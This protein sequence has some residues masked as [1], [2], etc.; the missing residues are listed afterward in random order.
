MATRWIT[1]ATALV[2][3]YVVVALALNPAG[4]P[5][6]HFLAYKAKPPK[7]APRFAR[8]EV[9]LL[10][11]FESVR[12]NVIKPH[13]ILVPANKNAEGILDDATHLQA[14]KIKSV[15]G[16]PKHVRRVGL[17]VSDQFGTLTLD[18]IKPELLLVPSALAHLSPPPS[19]NPS[20][21]NVDHFKCYKV[22]I[23]KGAPK[24]PSN[25][26]PVIAD[27]FEPQA[28]GFRLVKPLLLCL[29]V[30]KNGEGLKNPAGLLTCYKPKL[31]RGEPKH[32]R[33]EGAHISDQ[34][35]SLIL[36]TIKE[37]EF[38]VPSVFTT[39]TP[40]VTPIGP[41][42]SAT[43][44]ATPLP[45]GAGCQTETLTGVWQDDARSE[46]LS[47]LE[48]QSG[49][50]VGAL[51]SAVGLPELA[52][53]V[54]GAR[55]GTQIN[56][57]DRSGNWEVC[58]Q[59]TLSDGAE[60][61]TYRRVSLYG[62]GNGQLEPGEQCDD[63]NLDNADGCTVACKTTCG[64]GAL[65]PGEQCDGLVGVCASG[66]C[67]PNCTCTPV[68]GDAT[69][70]TP[71]EVCDGPDLAGNT[72]ASLGYSGGTLACVAACNG[73]DSSGCTLPA[74][75][76]PDP[77]TIAP[78]LDDSVVTT[79]FAQT[80]FLFTGPDRVQYGV[81][82]AV[83]DPMRA[84]VL[85]G[86][87]LHRDGFPVSG[88]TV[89]V[90]SHPEF[91]RTVSRA[92][93]AFDLAVNGGGLLLVDYRS[94]AFLP[95]QRKIDVPWQGF[96]HLPDVVLIPV[97]SQVSTITV[98]PAAPAQVAQG[99][100]VTDERGTRRAAVFFPTGT[101]AEVILPD[102]S[103][104]EVSTL[105]LRF[106][107]Y[108]VGASG[109]EAMPGVLP[110]TNGYTYAV[111]ISADEAPTK[112]N[113]R[114]VLLSQP[115]PLYVDNFLNFPVGGKVPSAYYDSDHGSWIPVPDGRVIRILDTTGGIAEVDTDGDLVA[116]DPAT[117]A[118]L[119]VTSEERQQL[120]SLYEPGDTL[121]RVQVTHLS[122]YDCNWPSP[123]SFT[124][125]C[126][127]PAVPTPTPE[128]HEPCPNTV[129]GSIVDCEN[130]TLGE[131]IPIVGTSFALNYSSK[132]AANFPIPLDIPITGPSVPTDLQS[133]DL[134]VSVAGR[135]FRH[136]FGSAPGQKHSFV[137]DR[138]DVYGRAVIGAERVRVVR[139]YMFPSAFAQ[140]GPFN[141]SFGLPA[142][143][144]SLDGSGQSRRLE[145]PVESQV[146]IGQLDA[147][148]VGLGGWTLDVHRYY[149]P[150]HRVLYLGSGQRR[151][152]SGSSIQRAL[153]NPALDPCS[154]GTFE[155]VESV[156]EGRD[157][158]VYVGDRTVPLCLSDPGFARG[159]IHRYRPDGTYER[160]AGGGA[161][162]GA[163]DGGPATAA[164]I[165]DPIDLAIGPDDS[166]HILEFDDDDLTI[167]VRRVRPDGTIET[168]AG[169][170]PW[171][172]PCNEDPN[173][174]P[175]TEINLCQT[176]G[177]DV[178]PDGTLYI[179][180]TDMGRVLAVRADG[181]VAT[182]A[183]GGFS[184]ADGIAALDALLESPWDVAVGP[185]GAIYFSDRANGDRVRRVTPD[186]VID[187]IAGV[188]G[189]QGYNG[190]GGPA[191]EAELSQPFRLALAATDN[192]TLY[193]SEKSASRVRSV[194]PDG[195][196]QTVAGG[197]PDLEFL[198]ENEGGPAIGFIYEGG[199]FGAHVA[200][201]RSGGFYLVAPGSHEDRVLRV[202]S[203]YPGFHGGGYVI[204]SS[205]GMELYHFESDGR[206]RQTRSAMTGHVLY[207]FLYTAQGRL[208]EVVD[209]DGNRTQIERDG[210][211][212]PTA[213]IAPFGQRTTLSLDS[214]GYLNLIEN[215][216][217]EAH[218]FTYSPEG[219]LLT[220]TDPR[221]FTSEYDY[222]DDGRL[223]FAEDP[224]GGSHTISRTTDPDDPGEVEIT[225]MTALGRQTRYVRQ[226]PNDDTLPPELLRPNLSY[227]RTTIDPDGTFN[228][229]WVRT[230]GIT[231]TEDSSGVVTISR[232][233]GDPRFGLQSPIA[234]RTDVT[235]PGSRH[236]V[237]RTE[238]QATL[239][240]QSQPLSLQSWTERT[241]INSAPAEY[242]RTFDALTRTYTDQTPEGRTSTTTI[243][244]MGRVVRS[245]V[246][247]LFPVDFTY[248]GHGRLSA[249]RQGS[250]EEER[251]TQFTYN[252]EGYVE[253]T[254][255]P[256]GR[257][258]SLEYDLA[259]RATR[260]VLPGV[261]GLREV[262]FGYDPNGNLDSLT[263][264]GR[265][266]HTF[267]FT[268]VNLESTYTPPDIGLAEHSTAYGY[269]E[270]RQVELVTRPDG[271]T[272][273]Y[274]Y[275]SGGRLETVSVQPSGEVRSHTYDAGTGRLIG[276]T[277]P[278]AT[279]TFTYDGSLLM[280]EQ[281]SGDSITST[282]TRTYDNDL[283]VTSLQV[284][285][286]PSIHFAYDNDD[287]LTKA[288]ALDPIGR[289]PGHGL[290]TD[291]AL[292]T[293]TDSLSY[294]AFGE[295]ATY[296]AESDGNPVLA[297]E[298]T[299]DKLGRIVQKLETVSGVTG[300]HEYRYDAAGR[301]DQVKQDGNVISEYEYHPNGN[302][303]GGFTP[304][305]GA[306]LD[307]TYDD[308]DRLLEYTTT[309]GGSTTYSYTENGEL[310]TR[311]DPSGTTTYSYDVFGNLRTV[312]LADSTVIEYLIDGRNR[313][314]GRKVNGV[315]VQRWMYKDQLSPIAEFDEAGNLVAQFVYGTKQNVPD[316]MIKGG[317]AYRI[318]S[319]HLGSPRLIVDA[320][321]GTIT[322][323]MDY[324]EFGNV[325]IDTN[326]GFQPFGFAGGI[327]DSDTG[328]VRFGA[329]DYDARVGRWT[330]K[331]PVRFRGGGANFYGYV[332]GDP[333]NFL[334]RNGLE[335]QMIV[336]MQLIRDWMPTALPD[337][338]KHLEPLYST[339]GG[340]TWTPLN[341]GNY[342]RKTDKCEPAPGL[343]S[344]LT[345]EELERFKQIYEQTK[346]E[347]G[348]QSGD[349]RYS[350]WTP[351]PN[352]CHTNYYD[353]VENFW[354]NPSY[355][356]W[357]VRPIP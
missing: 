286:E 12:T 320:S 271:Q 264:P 74:D 228:R 119:G 236:L 44:T 282:V 141:P 258:V 104:Q 123:C 349:T 211:G 218:T 209:G 331:D 71:H 159:V 219:L 58:D 269:N 305:T 326:P 73:F 107:E 224:A 40:S 303:A 343:P 226:P 6:D 217:S 284:N 234:A 134:T 247:G 62:C 108:T 309:I 66:T 51:F 67:Q 225:R 22:K 288:G 34:F 201:A 304:L 335:A 279:L 179:A 85:R 336:C 36:N 117:L 75:L 293:V 102:G 138:R 3:S 220:A 312:V 260:Q 216:N 2:G 294:S 250:D 240:D 310:L 180:A 215:P 262:L 337:A 65:D 163:G 221:N 32:S 207:E 184:T 96:T 348:G 308:Q 202:D 45:E 81:S 35:G 146:L 54:T 121:W 295:I 246:A 133:V 274:A 174:M 135:S 252:A 176:F 188:A 178:G 59:F 118:A 212:N 1:A 53:P 4:A 317:D 214:N 17:S 152:V 94:S 227:L 158:S 281:W 166:L 283:R 23:P 14:Y 131:T 275:D 233:L 297:V 106:S 70:D 273:E 191:N 342:R 238:R 171:F 24:L 175:A 29:P 199:S 41:S 10:D 307:A 185:N 241:R 101:Q 173:G 151:A 115:V 231:E 103:S 272:I 267:A 285:S 78:P 109:P 319:D 245:Q 68:C 323:Q 156:V 160:F 347:F 333:V 204:P 95:A 296:T 340:Q 280:S 256:I 122:T 87:V 194:G 127:T 100:S 9:E 270:D 197:T 5:D 187:T 69:A 196:I 27:A 145:V 299:R 232:S 244:G 265:P 268:P 33:K 25:L 330:A 287:L 165:G 355:G 324:D 116:D 47:L 136:S 302:R 249:V 97:D 210:S 132:I 162:G 315:V 149:D 99:S 235:T 177:I 111:E 20:T 79:F 92:D 190:D 192:S 356:Q 30:D 276:L 48:D 50:L 172:A 61:Y 76:P 43:P 63:G 93:G 229:A 64:N 242:I 205:D 322:Q 82:E 182:I 26:S 164:G 46:K 263:P 143:P 266:A 169:G 325:L 203:Y 39:P 223:I 193:I 114:D 55:S 289:H 200:P 345:D 254:T 316:Y 147:R 130:Q 339:D 291:T 88:V 222:D 278:H 186:G 144:A 42:P 292:G 311:T 198:H 168:V 167:R 125:Q 353:A 83:I 290:I 344:T 31:D 181:R 52:Q 153:G 327:Y 243:D 140:P 239:A 37:T 213:I 300:L 230:D 346:K 195:V 128:P 91:G 352:N 150:K 170:G 60:A 341:P 126:P 142:S 7:G 301:L 28:R 57:L 105:N 90:R 206:H 321:N 351:W 183:G 328:L 18:T 248:D 77:E 124:G 329:R 8:T 38:C 49:A 120:A 157:G 155:S 154:P 318:I 15:K 110:P 261:G 208:A 137:W 139:T 56:V 84:A 72:C 19:P 13:A 89:S 251:V 86:R 11:A 313:R 148:V 189:A 298:Y 112:L 259:A 129:P 314:I 350:P 354:N 306:I 332:K 277:G 253:T 237:R 16:E 357:T 98:G 257:T 338:W 80:Q 113:G 334:D 21:H 161:P 255:D